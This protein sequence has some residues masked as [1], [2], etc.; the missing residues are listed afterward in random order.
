MGIGKD[1]NSRFINSIKNLE[2]CAFHGVY[3]TKFI[4]SYPKLI[5]EDYVGSDHTFLNQLACK[6]N[7]LE[8]QKKL[9]LMHEPQSKWQ[10]GSIENKVKK[11]NRQKFFFP[12]S[13]VFI[14]SLRFA[15][16]YQKNFLLNFLLLIK[17]IPIY[18]TKYLVLDLSFHKKKF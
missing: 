2:T 14:K 18:I 3:R 15:T 7:F 9:M 11:N 10:D 4:K 1:L 12:F 17:L 13:K 5:L 6:G 16:S 8:V